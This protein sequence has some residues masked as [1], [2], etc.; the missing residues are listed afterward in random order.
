MCVWGGGGG[1]SIL[2]GLTVWI[3]HSVCFVILL[4]VYTGCW[5]LSFDAHSLVRVFECRMQQ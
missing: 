3:C 5:N 4:C 2:F 1:S